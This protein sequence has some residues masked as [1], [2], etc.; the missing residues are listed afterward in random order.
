MV[1]LAVLRD[2]GRATAGD[3]LDAPS[4][5]DDRAQDLGDLYVWTTEGGDLAVALTIA[6]GLLP[7][8][9][10]PYDPAVVYGIHFD[11]DDD[12]AAEHSIWVQFGV[13]PRTREVG[14][15]AR[16]VPGHGTLIGPVEEVIAGARGGQL[17]AGVR[18][19]PFFFDDEGF[20]QSLADQTLVI[21]PKQDVHAGTNA[22]AVVL[23]LDA[24]RI[25]GRVARVWATTGRLR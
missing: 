17:W 12:P 1:T 23:E 10:P 15:R 18:D 7:G 5:R 19:D 2:P 11:T 3:H 24:A 25:G 13:D 22:L 21:G 4:M 20:V 8:E 9:A 6:P 14:V 16:G